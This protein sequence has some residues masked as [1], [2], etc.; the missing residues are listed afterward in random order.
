VAVDS[1]VKYNAEGK[2]ATIYEENVAVGREKEAKFCLKNTHAIL[3]KSRRLAIF[4]T[5]SESDFWDTDDT[6][7]SG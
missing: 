1:S 2:H 6:D 3:Q 5:W 4:G 7:W